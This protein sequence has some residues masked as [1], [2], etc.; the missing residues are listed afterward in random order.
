MYMIVTY[1]LIDGD[2][3]QIHVMIDSDEYQ[4]HIMWLWKK[5]QESLQFVLSLHL[6]SLPISTYHNPKC[7]PVL[8]QSLVFP[9][10]LTPW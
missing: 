5:C 6:P 4:V 9:S 7:L 3:Y 2:D 8:T 10:V 1:I